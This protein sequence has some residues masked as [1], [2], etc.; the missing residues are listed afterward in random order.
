MAERGDEVFFQLLAA[1]I[2]ELDSLRVLEEAG[3]TP[4]PHRT[5]TRRLRVFALDSWRLALV[6]GVR[7]APPGACQPVLYETRMKGRVSPA[8]RQPLPWAA[9]PPGGPALRPGSEGS[10][11]RHHHRSRSQQE[12]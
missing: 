8:H 11:R 3:M 7:G 1:R 6:G 10:A 9:Q 4:A 12:P 5:V 2:I